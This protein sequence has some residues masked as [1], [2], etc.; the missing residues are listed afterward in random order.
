MGAKQG[1]NYAAA[2]NHVFLNVVAP[3]T[4]VDPKTYELEL[5]RICN[6][7]WYKMVRLS[8]SKVEV[9][10]MCSIVKNAPPMIIRLVASNPTGFVLQIDNYYETIDHTREPVLRS[11]SGF[12]KGPLDGQSTSAPHPITELFAQQRARAM[13]SSDTLYAYDWPQLFEAA[14]LTEWENYTFARDA[15]DLPPIAV[16]GEKE[17][18]VRQELVMC[19]PVTGNPYKNDW[20]A[21]EV[22]EN[23]LLVPIHNYEP[24]HNT[25]A[26]VAWLMIL[27]TP[28]YPDGRQIVVIC[29]DI[30]VDA[31]SFG[32]KEDVMFFKA[33]KYARD[34]GIPRLYLAA[35]SG[36][37]IGMAESLKKLFKV[38]WRDAN[39]PSKGYKYIYLEK[40][41][42]KAISDKCALDNSKMPILCSPVPDEP[43]HMQV[44]DIIGEEPD[45]GVENLMGSGLIA[46]ETARAYDEIFTLTLVIGRTVGIGAYLVRLGQRTIQRTR[47]S[48]IILTGHQALNKLLGRDIYT[49]N[50]QLGGPMIMFPNGVSH[51]LS[52]T[53]MESVPRALQWL[54]YI[55]SHKGGALPLRDMVGID[56][57]ERPVEWYP[58]R[59]SSYDPRLLCNG[60]HEGEK[61]LGGFFDRG[62]FVETLAGWAKTVVVG[63]GRLGGLPVGVIITENRTS[64]AL[65]P[66]DPAAEASQEKVVQQAGG[67]WFPDS[68][69]KTA[70][71]L[72]DFDREGLPCMIFANWRGFSGGQT[73]MF[74]EVLKFGSMIVDALV[75][76]QNPI[77]VYIP[78]FA[79]L[80][81]GAWVVVDH[82]INADVME[83]YAAE[84]ARGG[85][86]EAA[87]AATIKYRDRDI[88]ATAHRLDHA[89]VT[90]DAK[91]A[92]AK[93]GGN[94]VAIESVMKEI[95]TRE[96]MLFGVY[97]QVAEHFADLHDTPGR[98]KAKEVI[99]A[100]IKWEQSRHYFFWRLRRR[101]TEFDLSKKLYEEATSLAT[102]HRRDVVEN[103]RAWFDAKGGTEDTWNNDKKMMLWLTEKADDFAA[104]IDREK[105]KTVAE[106]VSGMITASSPESLKMVMSSLSADERDR[107]IAALK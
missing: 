93:K 101:L 105:A 5:R 76:Y 72:K 81:G 61:W 104:Y 32:T 51:M 89:L 7:Y 30:T 85:V 100:E 86:L 1:R 10:L 73:D 84:D 65:K 24:G 59:G 53:H 74:E 57:I 42:Y 18:F 4:V 39:D 47:N 49:A 31:G 58:T 43:S 68:A 28:E 99:R 94:D 77:F 23:G 16:D 45:L 29:N 70:Q 71:A 21:K 2:A 37:R 91:L 79:E 13:L 26:M 27:R 64:E 106:K 55:P 15:A 35:N 12:V 25:C 103:L 50:D 66:A 56:H 96:K 97:Q 107:I 8:I 54:S 69:Y 90:L 34:R 52:E 41:A 78:P 60:D 11:V 92:T 40:D 3:D 46:G 102:R 87:G 80:R 22:E 95:S 88:V 9:K 62:S 6:K 14:V 17:A 82:T 33:S 75:A 83:F 36:A 63:R 19:D 48:P 67:V 38:C 44:T 20:D 98:M